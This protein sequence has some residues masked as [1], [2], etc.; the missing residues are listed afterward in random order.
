MTTSYQITGLRNTPPDFLKRQLEKIKGILD[1]DN[2]ALD[3]EYSGK[4]L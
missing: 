1:S 4:E 3:H 2:V